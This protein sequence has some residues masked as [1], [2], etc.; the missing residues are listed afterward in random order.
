MAAFI[1]TLRQHYT[2]CPR[3]WIA[4]QAVVGLI[5]AQEA[6]Q[7]LGLHEKN[8]AAGIGHQ[9]RQEVQALLPES[10]K[11]DTPGVLG[12]AAGAR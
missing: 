5:S 10:M 7:Q 4:A 8:F 9:V 2:G 6:A 3:Q 12:S 1:Q 11:D